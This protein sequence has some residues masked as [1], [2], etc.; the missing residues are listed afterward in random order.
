MRF[1]EE[2][3]RAARAGQKFAIAVFDIDH[4]KRVNDTHGHAAGDLALRAVGAAVQAASRMTDVTA[5]Y[6]GEEFLVILPATDTKGAIEVAERLRATVAAE[7]IAFEGKTLSVTASFGIATLP[8]PEAGHHH[9]SGETVESVLRRADRALYH[10]KACGRDRVC[11][12]FVEVLD[13]S[14]A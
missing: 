4:F 13:E 7:R 9:T 1:A 14:A 10:A 2:L 8:P 11:A 6:G 5:R 12:D 3:S